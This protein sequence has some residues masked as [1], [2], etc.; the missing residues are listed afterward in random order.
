MT[1]EQLPR[2]PP[3]HLKDGCYA[4]AD[5]LEAHLN[6]AKAELERLRQVENAAPCVSPVGRRDGV[7]TDKAVLD[8]LDAALEA[9]AA[10]EPS[11]RPCTCHPDDNPPRPCPRKY[12]LSECRKAAAYREQVNSLALECAE[13]TRRA[14]QKS[15]AVHFTTKAEAAQLAGVPIDQLPE[16]Y[17]LCGEPLSAK[18][19][20]CPKCPP[21]RTNE[22]QR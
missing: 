2:I 10:D 6:A 15:N 9:G 13:S 21:S 14:A 20:P 8:K 16:W 7:V 5:A 22:Q 11:E 1:N 4:R 17:C 19:A 12:A 18:D 3:K